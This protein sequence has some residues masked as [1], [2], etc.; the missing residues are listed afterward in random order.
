MQ[1]GLPLQVTVSTHEFCS[2]VQAPG[3]A[4]VD[5]VVVDVV[6]VVVTGGVVVVGAGVVVVSGSERRRFFLCF[7]RFFLAEVCSPAR[8]AAVSAAGMLPA[9]PRSVA[10]RVVRTSVRRRTRS[11]NLV[12]SIAVILVVSVWTGH[13][14]SPQSTTL[15]QVVHGKYT[16][17][18][19]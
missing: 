8:T 12:S 17:N 16:V 7:F 19:W 2:T 4:V 13:R 3:G 1:S 15:R 9:M 5:V 18:L 10:M 14:L 6:V 11:S